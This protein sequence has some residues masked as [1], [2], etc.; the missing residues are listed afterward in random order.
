MII[1]LLSQKGGVGKSTLSINI[2][3]ELA[4]AKNQTLLIDADPQG[5]SSAWA[6]QRNNVGLP[7]IEGLSIEQK[8]TADIHTY[9]KST[10]KGTE[11]DY[12]HIVVDGPPRADEA[13]ARSI[14]AACD[15]VLIPVQPSLPDLWAA[16]TTIAL[17]KQAQASLPVKSAL[18]LSRV[19]S[20]TNLTK[21]FAELI[22]N[23]GLPVLKAKTSDRT[24]YASALSTC[25]TV[26]EYEP[27]SQAALEI[28]Q[29][30]A[31]LKKL[32]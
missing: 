9:V 16:R 5:T 27:S 32:K 1:G 28:K 29:I 31:E 18:I 19:K 4:K 22:T 8:T 24:A 20:N 6:E 13:L 25:Q 11:G 2:A 12:A 3:G 21:D 30:L 14:I 10:Q 7:A 26:G 17:V 23:E 15:V